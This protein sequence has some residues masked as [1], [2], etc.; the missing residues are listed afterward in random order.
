MVEFLEN[1]AGL[2]VMA[3]TALHSKTGRENLKYKRVHK[4]SSDIEFFVRAK[5]LF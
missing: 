3:F 5:G 4:V 1:W 2:K